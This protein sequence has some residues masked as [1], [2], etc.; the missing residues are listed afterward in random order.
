LMLYGRQIGEALADQ[1]GV[2]SAFVAAWHVLRWPLVLA[3]VLLSFE[4]IYNY[5]PSLDADAHR[6]WVT[7]GSVIG[8]GLWLAA[9]FGFRF[10]L[11]TVHSLATTYGS[12]GAV[13]VML[14]WFYLTAFAIVIGGTVNSE[15]LGQGLARRHRGGVRARPARPTRLARQARAARPRR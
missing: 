10:Y 1:L 14:L 6:P 11:G 8:V 9:S 4:A 12:L 5:A 3:F 15:I 7:P 13:F 2:G